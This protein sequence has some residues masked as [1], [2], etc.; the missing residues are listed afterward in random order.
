MGTA[1][2]EAPPPPFGGVSGGGWAARSDA[3]AHAAGLSTSGRTTLPSDPSPYDP[4]RT[5][6]LTRSTVRLGDPL[7]PFVSEVMRPQGILQ[8]K[9][10]EVPVARAR[11]SKGRDTPSRGESEAHVSGR[12]H[13]SLFQSNSSMTVYA[14]TKARL[15]APEPWH[16]VH[17]REFKRASR[18]SRPSDRRDMVQRLTLEEART[19]LERRR[20]LEHEAALFHAE[21]RRVAALDA[22]ARAASSRRAAAAAEIKGAF[23]SRREAN[24]Q[25]KNRAYAWEE[26]PGRVSVS[27]F[28]STA[29]T[30]TKTTQPRASKY[31]AVED[32]LEP[33]E[34]L[35]RGARQKVPRPRVLGPCAFVPLSADAY[36]E[37][38]RAQ[39]VTDERRAFADEAEALR[40]AARRLGGAAPGG[41]AYAAYFEEFA[42]SHREA[43]I[44]AGRAVH[45]HTKRGTLL[46]REAASETQRQMREL[47]AFEA[48]VEYFRENDLARRLVDRGLLREDATRGAGGAEMSSARDGANPQASMVRARA[49][50]DARL[51]LANRR[52]EWTDA[53]SEEGDAEPD[54]RAS[55][56]A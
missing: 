40:A 22:A 9:K 33:A 14:S 28:F 20:A 47:D 32:A 42:R 25:A 6:R 24:E 34:A 19:P 46:R 54:S 43:E 56:E 23:S 41:A 17:P 50:A 36:A 26:D 8:E 16:D 52:G 5:S 31:E 29:K 38:R 35:T 18:R 55:P 21:R 1:T 2:A 13:P 51:A 7:S 15:R 45:A 53:S 44:V 49:A 30:K 48:R 10:Y 27:A 11:Y 12:A 4:P 37:A 3:Y 39:T